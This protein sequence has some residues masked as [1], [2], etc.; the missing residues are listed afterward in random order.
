MRIQRSLGHKYPQFHTYHS[1]V[2]G[3]NIVGS[4]VQTNATLL[5]HASMI[6]KQQ[7]CWH[8]LALKFDQFQ[9]SSNN[10]QQVATTR[11]NTQHGVQTLATSWAQQCCVLLANNVVSVCTGLKPRS[12]KYYTLHGRKI[13]YD[14]D[15]RLITSYYRKWIT[16]NTWDFGFSRLY[17]GIKTAFKALVIPIL[18]YACLV[19]VKHTKAIEAIQR[20]VSRL[21]CGPDKEYPESLLELKWDSLELRRKYLCLVQM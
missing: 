19:L 15:I 4:A 21:I 16:I 13:Q 8:L 20:R 2:R 1:L 5:D 14:M 17:H 10:L 3:R 12:V 6:A 11:N 18:E 9:T 7:K